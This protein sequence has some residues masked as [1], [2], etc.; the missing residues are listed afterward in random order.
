MLSGILAG[1]FSGCGSESKEKDGV[2]VQSVSA[3]CGMTDAM[4]IDQYAGLVTNGKETQIKR[5]SDRKIAEVNV[6]VGDEVT[7]DQVLFTYDAEQAQNDLEKKRLELEQLQ[8]TL[9]TKQEE[10]AQLER[11]KKKA[12]ADEQLDYTLKIQEA[13]TAISETNY[14]I[15]LKQK[16][17]E[18]TA[19]ILNDLQVRAP[20]DGK[21]ESIAQLEDGGASYGYGGDDS[22]S[23]SDSGVDF[24]KLVQTD[25]VRVKGKLNESNLGS[26]ST[27]M[28]MIIRSRIDA[29]KTWKG[30]VTAI[31]T[32]SADSSDDNQQIIYG[33]SGDSEMTSSSNYAFYVTMENSDE[34]M[35]GQHVYIEP[36]YGQA[37]ASEEEMRLPSAYIVSPDGG[38][39]VWAEG[40]NGKLEKK[41]IKLGAYS[42]EDDTYPVLSGLSGEDYIAFPDAGY[43]EGML[44]VESDLSSYADSAVDGMYA[45][46][47]AEW[48]D[49]DM[50]WIPE[51]IPEEGTDGEVIGGGVG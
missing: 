4:Q 32:K 29:S 2:P 36:D 38:A 37:D 11:D 46:S 14:N 9:K 22:S 30:T 18:K 42:E 15:G 34:L 20:Y 33:D 43:A 7:K 45:D 12:K 27:E 41:A 13:D 49:S 8:N 39:F 25:V 40:K 6:Q 31:D 21:I 1:T 3:V 50:E 5:Q 24:I 35:V 23:S 19:A 16:E 47:A 26:I 48:A 28:P 10:K 51:D 44:C 17:I